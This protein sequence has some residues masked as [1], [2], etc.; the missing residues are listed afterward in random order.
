MGNEKQEGVKIF[1]ATG[2]PSGVI[3]RPERGAASS[4]N[5]LFMAASHWLS[6]LECQYPS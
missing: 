2:K 3:A 1:D 4:A 5:R 6:A